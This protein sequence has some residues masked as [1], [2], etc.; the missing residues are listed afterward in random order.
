MKDR[1]AITL[2]L[3]LICCA[4]LLSL[5]CFDN[6]PYSTSQKSK[7]KKTLYYN[8]REE[9]DNLDPAKAYSQTLYLFI[10]QIYE[11][12]LEFHYLKRPSVLESLTAKALPQT[13][14]LDKQG[15]PLPANAD[16]KDAAGITYRFTIKKGIL[17]QNHPCFAV[18]QAG[19]HLWHLQENESFGQ[20]IVQPDDLLR[21][22]RSKNAVTLTR[23]LK[24]ADY[25]YQFK[26][27]A[28]PEN[29]C[30]LRK[31]TLEKFIVGFKKTSELIEADQKRLVAEKEKAKLDGLYDRRIKKQYY[32]DLRDKK[33]DISGIRVIDDYTFEIQLTR[34]YPQF[35]YW[36]T[37]P[38]FSPV[39]WE[40][41]RFYMQE[42]AYDYNLSLKR[43]PVGT[44]PYK[45]TENRGSSRIVLERNENYR[46]AYYPSQGE[47]SDQSNG[48]LDAA[49]KQVP[50]ID[51]A[52]YSLEKEPMPLWNK[53]VQGYYDLL[54]P[55]Q[56]GSSNYDN[57]VDVTSSGD[58][59]ASAEMKKRKIVLLKSSRPKIRYFAFNM[60]DKIVGGFSFKQKKLRQA[61]SIAYDLKDQIDIIEN[62]RG[63][64]VHSPLP[65][66]IFGVR[67]G[68]DGINNVVYDWDDLKQQ[69][70][71]KPIQY[72]KDLLEQAGYKNGIDPQTGSPL[73]IR[74]SIP[75]TSGMKS[76]G[77][78]AKKQFKKLGIELEIDETT[79]NKWKEKLK[80]GDYQFI[81]YGWNADYPDAE[82]FMF[83]LYGPNKSVGNGGI[84]YANYDSPQYN[85]LFQQMETMPNSPQRQ[86]IIDKLIK[87][88]R[89][90]CPWIYA[91]TNQDFTMLQGWLKNYKPMFIGGGYLKYWDIDTDMRDQII[92]ENNQPIAYPFWIAV[93]TLTLFFIYA[94]VTAYK[95]DRGGVSL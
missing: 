85:K 58:S 29:G 33:Y 50:F 45:L 93:I 3:F 25:V 11:P 36:M 9:P 15:N 47:A 67:A 73:K 22:D 65:V 84:N 63:V 60:Q 18:D 34:L 62:G 59:Q 70:K 51:R 24:A 69:P 39:P 81:W 30:P 61:I 2:R 72:A 89:E 75:N 37:M 6:N 7:S 32:L 35:K 41:D 56:L 40:V 76:I 46:K 86:A 54:E 31:D 12:L 95:R 57:A 21:Q 48:L 16:L 92:K 83:L 71:L 42:A 80:T 90:D 91:Y 10:E 68:K 26:R 55:H 94:A 28:D 38:F 13:F 27:M 19:K 88:A 74:F 64:L 4:I 1:L 17:Y 49:N 87:I 44:G 53:F 43:F 82:N 52:I 23:E 66:G 8:F 20:R 77:K 14:F 5:G 78:F 79:L